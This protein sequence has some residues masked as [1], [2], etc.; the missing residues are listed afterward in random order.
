MND[1][2]KFRVWDK[3]EKCYGHTL[4]IMPLMGGISQMM[5]TATPGYEERF[6]VEQCTG[7]L[8]NNGKLI[9]EGDVIVHETYGRPIVTW[10]SSKMQFYLTDG[11][12]LLH[13]LYY[14]EPDAVEVV[15]NIH[16]VGYE[17]HN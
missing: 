13:P 11:T 3:D 5:S 2:F 12:I 9:F 16:E 10:S 15:G 8:D 7:M 17:N 4:C 6:I 1:R 14:E